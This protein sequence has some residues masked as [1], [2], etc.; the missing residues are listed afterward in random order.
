M[1]ETD[2]LYHVR[3]TFYNEGPLP[4]LWASSRT[5][6]GKNQYVVYITA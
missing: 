5:A 2:A 4:L 1:L 3:P 6:R